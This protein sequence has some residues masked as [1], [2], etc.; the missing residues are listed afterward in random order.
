MYVSQS[1]ASVPLSPIVTQSTSVANS[2]QSATGV[3]SYP[4]ISV[5]NSGY[6]TQSTA[7]VSFSPNVTHTS[8]IANSLYVTQTAASVPQSPIVTQTSSIANSLYVS[9]SVANVPVFC[10]DTV[11]KCCQLSLSP[12]W[13][14]VFH[15]LL[16]QVL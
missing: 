12:S 2:V 1:V 3:P 16:L 4:V 7:S 9:Q 13:L 11:Y 15:H 8:S 14:V 6:V 10:C 5:A